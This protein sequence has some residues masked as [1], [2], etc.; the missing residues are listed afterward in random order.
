MAKGEIY[1][2]RSGRVLPEGQAFQ[3]L[4]GTED[5]EPTGS[6]EVI[7][8]ERTGRLFCSCP[9]STRPTCRHRDMFQLFTEGEMVDS[10]RWYSFDS[11]TWIKGLEDELAG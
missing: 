4:K 11:G 10:N 8:S 3:C 1:T 9:A 7:L 6:Y 5:F 2:F